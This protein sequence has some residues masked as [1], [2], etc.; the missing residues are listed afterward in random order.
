MSLLQEKLAKVRALR[1]QQP[2]PK[3]EKPRYRVRNGKIVLRMRAVLAKP[4]PASNVAKLVMN[5]KFQ[6]L[7]YDRQRV[8]VGSPC[9]HCMPGRPG[10]YK[11]PATGV[12]DKC[13]V[14]HGKGVLDAR[15]KAYDDARWRGERGPICHMHSAA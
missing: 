14:C 1:Q 15:D 5:P 13:Y 2:E 3:Q 11:N 10:R 6:A 12:V 4:K 7:Q 9:Q 8:R